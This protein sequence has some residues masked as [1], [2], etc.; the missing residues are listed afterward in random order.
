MS[1]PKKHQAIADAITRSPSEILFNGRLWQRFK[2]TGE[3]IC[4]RVLK[5][6]H[7]TIL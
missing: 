4:V 3:D 7:A 5:R 1:R 2:G 6:E